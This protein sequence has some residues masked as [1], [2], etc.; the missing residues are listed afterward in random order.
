MMNAVNIRYDLLEEVTIEAVDQLDLLMHQLT[1]NPAKITKV[2]LREILDSGVKIYIASDNG[3][4]VGTVSVVIAKQ[5]RWYKGWLEDVVVDE[6]YRGL[7]IGRNLVEAAVLC[8][9][10]EHCKTLNMTSR[11]GREAAWQLYES[12]GFKFRDTRAYRLEL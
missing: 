6:A 12:L 11:P 3:K 4:I 9:R 8:A 7:G 1:P 2:R 10:R 5:M